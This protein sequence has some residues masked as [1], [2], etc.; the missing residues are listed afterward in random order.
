MKPGNYAY[1]NGM[2]VVNAVAMAGGYTYRADK[3]LS[4]SSMAVWV[5][6]KSVSM[7]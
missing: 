3:M 7:K 1:A 4:P 6:K 5:V 2:S